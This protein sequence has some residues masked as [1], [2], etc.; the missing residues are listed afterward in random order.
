MLIVRIYDINLRKCESVKDGIRVKK[1]K[2]KMRKKA[3]KLSF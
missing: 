2:K 3:K 1:S